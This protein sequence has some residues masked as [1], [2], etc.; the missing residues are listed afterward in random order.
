MSARHHDGILGIGVADDALSLRVTLRGH[1]VV[2]N[3]EQ[4]VHIKDRFVV[5]KHLLD[6]FKLIY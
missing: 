4:I 6:R 1:R 3:S 2:I 5:Q